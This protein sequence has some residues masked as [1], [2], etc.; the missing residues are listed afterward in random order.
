MPYLKQSSSICKALDM[1]GV[2]GSN[3][4]VPTTL[5]RAGSRLYEAGDDGSLR[6]YPAPNS[7]T[8]PEQIGRAGVKSARN[9]PALYT[10]PIPNLLFDEIKRFWN[11]VQMR[12]PD[13]CW[14]WCGACT[15]FGYGRFKL[16]GVL[17]L[18]HRVAY[19]LTTGPIPPSNSRRGVKI[20]MHSCDRPSCCN[21]RHLVLGSLSAN[22]KDMT[23]KGRHWSQTKRHAPLL[24]PLVLS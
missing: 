6:L 19:A 5:F 23:S 24:A 21:P 11:S 17:Y 12:G 14:P 8:R 1:G 3:P 18:P 7:R 13:D 2:T 15:R 10:L 4:V 20:V 22:A 16:D 9:T